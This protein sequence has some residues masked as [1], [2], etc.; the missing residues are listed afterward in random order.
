VGLFTYPILQA[1]DILLYQADEVPVGEDQR[2]HLE[3]SRTLAQRFNHRFGE[4]F[5]VPAP[6]IVP[7][8][9]KI[10]D[11]QDPTSKMSK[12]SSAPQGIIDLLDEPAAIRRKINRAVT[13]AES[14]V[15]VDE[16]AKP[17]VTNLLRIFAAL[18]GDPIDEIAARYGDGGYGGFKKDLG[19][20]VVD[21]FAPIRERTL[22]YLDDPDGLD[23]LLAD[24][25]RRAR[26][27]ASETMVAVRD[28]CGFPAFGA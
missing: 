11:L 10:T 1:A 4:T 16:E 12:S 5:T 14:V 9:S 23:A 2:Q 17:G 7:A 24:G 3:L 21:T 27:I 25:A 20:L 15:R 13:D 8:V 28:R 18:S 6:Y 19:E 26:V 22:K